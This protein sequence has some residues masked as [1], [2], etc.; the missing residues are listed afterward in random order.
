MI[1]YKEKFKEE[2][3]K[4]RLSITSLA[5]LTNISRQSIS[6][7]E[8]GKSIPSEK[9]IKLLAKTLKI[10]PSEISDIPDQYP[11]SKKKLSIAISTLE[12]NN[13]ELKTSDNNIQTILSCL[14]QINNKQNSTEMLLKA[15]LQH[16]NSIIYL[17]DISQKYVFV[18]NSFLK[19]LSLPLTYK[20]EGKLDS[21]LYT[22]KEA[23][24]NTLEDKQVL[25]KGAPIYNG[26]RYIFGTKKQKWG[27]FFK[28]PNT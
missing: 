27:Y 2:R 21:D 25:V 28:N 3:K 16:S 10:N 15:I 24:E 22:K 5:E 4:Q 18:S 6:K 7:W 8:N 17:K 14:K 19:Y 1:F 12:H 9:K 20:I 23:I 26:E 13:N 11:I